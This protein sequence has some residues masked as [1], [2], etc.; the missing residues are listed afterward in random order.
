MLLCMEYYTVLHVISLYSTS[1]IFQTSLRKLIARAPASRTQSLKGDVQFRVV[2]RGVWAEY[3]NT[4]GSISKEL[5]FVAA[6]NSGAAVAGFLYDFSKDE[7]LQVGKSLLA[8]EVNLRDNLL[9]ITTTSALR[10]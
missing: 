5:R 8:R 1:L 3:V 6:D 9:R 10:V 4:A 2:A 7:K